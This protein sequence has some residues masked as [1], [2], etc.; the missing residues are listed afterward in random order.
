MMKYMHKIMIP[1][2]LVF[3]SYNSFSQFYYLP[4]F[5]DNSFKKEYPNIFL[6]D[7]YFEDSLFE[8]HFMENGRNC[9]AIFSSEGK[10][11]RYEIEEDYF[12]LPIHIKNYIEQK[13]QDC[14]TFEHIYIKE[15][16]QNSAYYKFGAECYS[17]DL[18]IKML[19]DGNIIQIDT[20]S[21]Y[22]NRI[23]S[24]KDL[25]LQE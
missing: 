3:F 18:S 14:A 21:S 10:W 23:I 19:E 16:T 20:I 15:T 22:T 9:I 13:F 2:F 17:A 11:I 1:I 8:F 4:S 25:L 5:I 6:R 12:M 7:W 24:T